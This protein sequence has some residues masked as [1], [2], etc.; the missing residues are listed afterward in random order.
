MASG[1]RCMECLGEG[2]KF[3]LIDLVGGNPLAEILPKTTPGLRLSG[4]YSAGSFSLSFDQSSAN[5]SCGTL[6]PQPL[7][8]TVERAGSQL[9]IKVPIAP[10]PLALALNPDGKLAG[11][12]PIEVAGP[13][14][15]WTH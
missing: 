11:P 13:P 9:L 15:S 12:E 3:W 10:K 5:V 8:Y 6:V 1:R 2:M 4:V 7:P 14:A